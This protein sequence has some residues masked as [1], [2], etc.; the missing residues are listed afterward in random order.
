MLVN[1]NNILIFQVEIYFNGHKLQ[2]V[3]F[4]ANSLDKN[5]ISRMD[6][7]HKDATKKTKM[8]AIQWKNLH[9][10]VIEATE[11][12]QTKILYSRYILLMQINRQYDL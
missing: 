8:T 6:A 9:R 4:G 11:K 3:R 1:A 10:I 2:F 7:R 5:S 12:E